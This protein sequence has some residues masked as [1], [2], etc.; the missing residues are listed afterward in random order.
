MKIL[1]VIPAYNESRRLPALLDGIKAR[2]GRPE[3]A[4]VQFLVVDDGGG[5]EEA[6]RLAA[7]IAERGLGE[8]IKLL[9]LPENRGKGGALKAGFARG[10]REGFDWLGFM[11]ADGAVS[12]ASLFEAI[13]YVKAR[14]GTELAAVAGSRVNMLGRSISRNPLRHYAGRAFA[15]FV[16][17]Y[18]GVAMYDSQCGLKLFRAD[19][20]A[21]Y[22]E[23]PTD[24][25]WVWDTELVLAMLHGGETVHELPI[26]W[27]EV[28]GSK[29]SLLRDPAVMAARLIAFKRRL[30]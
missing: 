22:L 3:A 18:F 20:L 23:L 8:F 5:P 4:G 14:A 17:L 29:V 27:R 26:D 16:S 6:G 2:L 25:R 12:A 28:E 9:E 19:A 24:F 7:L 21:K 15:T 13:A 1:V 10:L 11:D 30:P